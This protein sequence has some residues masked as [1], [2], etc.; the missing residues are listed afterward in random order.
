MRP[1][2]KKYTISDLQ[3]VHQEDPEIG[4]TSYIIIIYI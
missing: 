2:E 4:R 3:K 1:Y